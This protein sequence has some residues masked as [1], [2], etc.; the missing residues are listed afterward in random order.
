MEAKE[1]AL[2]GVYATVD[3]SGVGRPVKVM[4]V[5]V[6]RWPD[7]TRVYY[8]Q[9]VIAGPSLN[10]MDG[11]MDITMGPM[12]ARLVGD[13]IPWVRDPVQG[14]ETF[15]PLLPDDIMVGGVYLAQDLISEQWVTIQVLN[16]SMESIAEEGQE[17]E[18]QDSHDGQDG[19]ENELPGAGME[20]VFR[21]QRYMLGT[22][23][24]GVRT[25]PYVTGPIM[26]RTAADLRQWHPTVTSNN[27]PL[28]E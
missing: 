11:G 3:Q 17:N 2:G 7:P 1:I 12:M 4:R 20:K 16:Y 27:A 14:T 10:V 9:A 6:E 25:A 23:V 8:C 5:A 26:S 24:N 13:L 15:E 22:A 19:D 18:N 21:V 28:G